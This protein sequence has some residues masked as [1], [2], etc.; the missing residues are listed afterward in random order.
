MMITGETRRSVMAPVE[1]T[2]DNFDVL[3]GDGMV[4]VDFW[5]A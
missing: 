4:L 3:T 2:T 1:L 5:A